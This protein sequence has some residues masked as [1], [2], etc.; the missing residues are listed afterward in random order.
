MSNEITDIRDNFKSITFSEYS[1][2]KVKLELIKCINNSKIEN[3]CNWTAE[4]ICAGHYIDLWD[5][6]INYM[7]KYINL[8]NPKLSLYIELRFNKFKE[9]INNYYNNILDLRNNKNIRDLFCEIICVLI[10]S[11]KKLKIDEIKIQSED[12]TNFASLSDKLK[13]KSTEYINNFFDNEDDPCEIY[14]PCN[15]FI[16]S[17]INKSLQQ[18]IYWVEWIICFEIY[19]AKNKKFLLGKYRNFAPKSFEKDIIMIIWEI[20]F[21]YSKQK[22]T[23]SN[24]ICNSL[25]NLFC[26]KYNKNTKKKRRI[27]I[28]LALQIIIEN[29]DNNISIICNKEKINNIILKVDNIYKDI[30]KNEYPPKNNYLNKNNKNNKNNEKSLTKL[31]IL[32]N[33]EAFNDSNSSDNEY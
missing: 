9:I 13:A 19:L 32:N 29:Y 31:N 18:S 16:Y 7:C 5:I 1:K 24:K 17:I 33:F 6:I 14:I 12:I 27:I 4:L 10:F 30:K 8:G 21:Y 11:S 25:F 15:E 28:Y 20:I 3:A 2:S 22:N 23:L 26:I